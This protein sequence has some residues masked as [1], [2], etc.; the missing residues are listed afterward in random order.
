MSDAFNLYEATYMQDADFITPLDEKIG[1]DFPTILEDAETPLYQ[2]C[3]KYK[4]LSAIVVLYRLKAVNGWSDKSFN[5][6][7]EILHDMLPIYNVLL[8]S[9]YSERKFLKTFDLG[10]E[11]IHACINDCCLFRKENENVDKC[12]TCGSSRWQE[13]E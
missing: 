7:L 6:L 4:K 2:G 8:K 5:G 10:Y 11:K 3:T 1:D 13:D 12:P 9:V